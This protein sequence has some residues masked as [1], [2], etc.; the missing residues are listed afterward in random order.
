MTRTREEVNELG[1]FEAASFQPDYADLTVEFMPFNSPD[2]HSVPAW[3]L[4][5]SR[6]ICKW[7]EA[8]LGYMGV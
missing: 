8:Y 4:F 1:A 5:F 7:T 6:R 2:A 3:L